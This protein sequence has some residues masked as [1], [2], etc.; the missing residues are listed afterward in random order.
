MSSPEPIAD[1]HR[2]GVETEDGSSIFLRSLTTDLT[3]SPRE[4]G[5]VYA[6]PI[7]STSSR[8][9]SSP[10][11][12]EAGP[13][14]LQFQLPSPQS[15]PVGSSSSSPLSIRTSSSFPLSPLSE[16]SPVSLDSLASPG[17][18]VGS[19]VLG[20]AQSLNDRLRALPGARSS[21]GSSDGEDEERG[22]DYGSDGSWEDIGRAKG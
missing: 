4:G 5:S 18:F 9:P 12:D 13:S 8:G 2:E 17:V 10:L 19:S 11:T 7:S 22:S 14:T 1:L 20:D 6:T 21:S 3:R 15:L 16:F